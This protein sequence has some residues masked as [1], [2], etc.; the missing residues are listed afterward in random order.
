MSTYVIYT[1]AEN[2]LNFF[3]QNFFIFLARTNLTPNLF[4]LAKQ[5]FVLSQLDMTAKIF[6]LLRYLSCSFESLLNDD[7]HLGIHEIINV[8]INVL[9]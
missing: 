5:T 4:K 1:M 6:F 2:Y 8:Y 7:V 9:I 3:L